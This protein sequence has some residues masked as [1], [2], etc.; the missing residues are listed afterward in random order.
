MQGLASVLKPLAHATTM[1]SA[2][3]N[4]SISVI[5]PILTALLEKNTCAHLMTIVLE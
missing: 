3:K 5:K 1:L 4:P 2:E